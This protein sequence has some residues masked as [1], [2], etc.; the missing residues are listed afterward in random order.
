VATSAFY[1]TNG[2]AGS[3]F[4]FSRGDTFFREKQA[5]WSSPLALDGVRGHRQTNPRGQ[6]AAKLTL[7]PA[8]GCGGERNTDRA[9]VM[10]SVDRDGV[11][12]PPSAIIRARRSERRLLE[13][14]G[15]NWTARRQSSGGCGSSD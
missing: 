15:Q 5:R 7:D 10:E 12:P 6:H 1:A 3:V 9:G 13:P 14:L 2:S 8:S 11:E 4:S